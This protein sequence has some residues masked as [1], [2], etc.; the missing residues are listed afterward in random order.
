MQP[1]KRAFI[2][3]AA[4]CLALAAC[5]NPGEGPRF[6]TG[7]QQAEP[8]IEAIHAYRDEHGRYPARLDDLVPK[9]YSKRFLDDHTPGR[10]I[11]FFYQTNPDGSFLFE[12]VYSYPGRNRCGYVL[13]SD[14]VKWECW[15]HY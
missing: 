11:P 14:P 10:P 4:I 12:F 5:D 9:F 8:V 7:R 15:G 3:I 13:N 2:T 1:V 6:E